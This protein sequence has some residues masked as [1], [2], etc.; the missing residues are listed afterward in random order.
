M[1]VKATLG[2]IKDVRAKNNDVWMELVS[3][4]FELD[5]VRASKIME[6]VRQNDKE[7]TELTRELVDEAGK[8]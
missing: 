3:L 8:V 5:P 1:S 6:R 2:K 7:V 4:A